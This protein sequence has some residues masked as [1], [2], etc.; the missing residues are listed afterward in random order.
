MAR[1][2]FRMFRDFMGVDCPLHNCRFVEG[3]TA[4]Q[5]VELSPVRR[6]QRRRGVSLL[7]S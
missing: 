6:S 2:A 7:V 3:F 5:A 4:V 1:A